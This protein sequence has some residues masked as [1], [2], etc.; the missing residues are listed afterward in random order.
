MKKHIITIAGRPGS[1]KSTTA[2]S[3]ASKLEYEHFSSGDL[4]RALAKERGTDVLGA[5]LNAENNAEIDHLVDARLRDIGDTKSDMVV[6]SRTAW[7]WMPASFKVFL[8]LDLE[9][10]AH[11]IINVLAERKDLNE[12]ISKDPKEYAA[13]LKR[14]LDSENHRYHNLYK[15]DPGKMSN[16][17][18]VV[19]T[20]NNNLAQVVDLILKSYK[21]WLQP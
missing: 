16:Y 1:G 5:N 20:S 3:V 9:I 11:R 15:I 21:Q 7:H 19:D 10:A 12:E 2:R 14:R 4:F 6:D 8:D 18:L 17:D 13:V